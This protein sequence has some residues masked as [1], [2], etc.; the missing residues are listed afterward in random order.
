M[1][2]VSA[3]KLQNGAPTQFK[4]LSRDRAFRREEAYWVKRRI[5]D[6]GWKM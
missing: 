4:A 3:N 2:S 5:Y 1:L 6:N